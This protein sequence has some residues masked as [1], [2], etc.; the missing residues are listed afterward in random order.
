MADERRG[1]AL[2]ALR[3]A[4]IEEYALLARE[5]EQLDR[6]LDT[7]LAR[8]WK[9]PECRDHLQALGYPSWR[10]VSRED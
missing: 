2:R 7:A 10:E 6:E 8:M 5:S 4:L 3:Q 1:A 9:C